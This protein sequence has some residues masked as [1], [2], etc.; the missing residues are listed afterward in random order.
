MINFNDYLLYNEE[1]GQLTWRD[2]D[3]VLKRVRNKPATSLHGE[4]YRQVGVAGK[5]Y[6]A[7]RVIWHMLHGEWSSK[8]ID[9]INGDRSDNRLVNLREASR[10]ENIRNGKG[11]EH[12]SKYKGVSWDKVRNKWTAYGKVNGKVKN[13]GRYENEEEAALA[14]DRF[15]EENFKQFARLNFHP[16]L[17]PEAQMVA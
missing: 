9:H 5:T 8:D 2:T 17:T 11:R 14:Y 15:A 7:H 10:R 16:A 12:T 3:C 6:L 4:G 13:L 1:T